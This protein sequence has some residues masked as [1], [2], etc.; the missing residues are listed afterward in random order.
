MIL[1]F[2][3]SLQEKNFIL[4]GFPSKWTIENSAQHVLNITQNNDNRLQCE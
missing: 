4:N 2:I 3:R 1:I